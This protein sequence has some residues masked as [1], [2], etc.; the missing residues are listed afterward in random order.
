MIFCLRLVFSLQNSNVTGTASVIA[1]A[2]HVAVFVIVIPDSDVVA[3]TKI[4]YKST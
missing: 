4:Y 1:V 2:I 3:L